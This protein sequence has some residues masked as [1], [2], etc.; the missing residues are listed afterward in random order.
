MTL[1]RAY[2]RRRRTQNVITVLGIAVGVMV[3]ITALSLTNGF[4]RALVDATLRATPQ[5]T[6]NHY[7]PPSAPVDEV[8]RRIG[9][10]SDVTAFTPY[11]A[12]KALLTRPADQGRSAGVDFATIFGVTPRAADVLTLTPRE[13]DL[14]RSLRPGEIVLGS[15]LAQSVGAFEGDKLRLL[16]SSQRRGELRVKGLFRTGNFV[17]DSGYAFVRIET[18]QKLANT[19]GITGYQA[20]LRDPDRAPGVGRR[21]VR[22]EPMLAIPWQDLNRTLIDQLALQKRVIG[23]VVFLIVIV[24]AFG[25]ANVLTLTVFEKTS[26]IAILRAIGAK[27][28]AIQGAFVL[29]GLFLGGVG[30]VLGNV[31][32][33]LVAAYFTVRPFQLPGDLYFIS[34]LPVELRITDV[35]WVNAV[36]LATTLLAAL[37]PARRAAN[38]EPARVIR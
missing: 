1:A 27:R 8:E 13:R 31:L 19:K 29:Q 32:A 33:L 7:A 24:A 18:L 9:R 37:L 21:L 36:S 3:L 5:L 35:L 28:R 26:D 17:I 23:F 34:A 22:G 14:V 11:F 15:A 4:S 30:L 20:R 16:N 12:D 6:L 25:I 10:D 38:I 2:L